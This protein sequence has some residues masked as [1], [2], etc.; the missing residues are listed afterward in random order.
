LEHPREVLKE[1]DLVRAQVLAIDRERRRLKLGMKQLQ[2]TTTDE[3][4]AEHREGQV[5]TGRVVEV[6]EDGGARV[7]VADRVFARCLP[8]ASQPGA[9]GARQGPADLSVLTAMLEA[10]WKQGRAP[11]PTPEPLR[12]GQ[13]RSFRIVTLDKAAKRIELEPVA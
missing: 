2:P 12:A 7:E 9:G 1:G 4:I 10:K 6:T 13:V 11:S 8:P 3:Y 5:V